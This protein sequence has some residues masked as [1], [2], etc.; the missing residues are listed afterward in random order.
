M[1]I[2]TKLNAIVSLV[3]LGFVIILSVT[4]Y[5]ARTVQTIHNLE[6]EITRLSQSTYRL[7]LE[8]RNLLVSNNRMAS[9]YESWQSADAD[10]Q[11]SMQ[12]ISGHPGLR[13]LSR[14]ARD[15]VSEMVDFWRISRFRIDRLEDAIL[16]VQAVEQI[17]DAAKRGIIPTTQYATTHGAPDSALQELT[18][19]HSLLLAMDESLMTVLIQRSEQ[20]AE[21]IAAEVAALQRRVFAAVA[22]AAVVVLVLAFVLALRFT[23]S[24]GRRIGAIERV[25]GQVAERDITVR[26]ADSGK[27]EIGSL[28][29]H[30][31]GVLTTLALFF[32]SADAAIRQ[33]NELKDT[34]ASSSNE[35][36]AALNQITKNIE[37]IKEQF[38]TLDRNIAGSS[39]A[40]Q[41]IDNQ[42]NNLSGSI[43]QQ[44]GSVTQSS[45]AIEQMNASIQSVARVATERKERAENLRTVVQDGGEQ[46]GATNEV[47]RAV[48][49][50]IDD[51]LQVIEVINSISSQT[52]LLSMNAAI[53]SAHAGEAGRGFA[54]VAEE[55]RKLSES[56]AENATR[57]GSSLQSITDQIR[58]ALLS[59][60]QSYQSYENIARDVEDFVQAMSEIAASMQELSSASGE[61]LVSSA[62]VQRVTSEIRDGAQV[63][64]QR[65][66]EISSA[67]NGIRDIS[68]HVVQG[69]N[70]IDSGARE[71]LDSMV[72]VSDATTES[73]RR[74]EELAELIATF[75]IERRQAEE[76]AQAAADSNA[77]ATTGV[78]L[79]QATAE[80]FTTPGTQSQPPTPDGQTL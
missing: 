74:M 58:E 49:S 47:V 2:S 5:A 63:M 45:A 21:S 31:N 35:S 52:N 55:I 29:Q 16:N 50:E 32:S 30:I 73:K 24:L 76:A 56:T 66:N 15:S 37:S 68:S 64:S 70:E 14:Q 26:M 22:A 38:E 3:I 12:A 61:V 4:V 77:A 67:M 41:S 78:T 79:A 65:S 54:V 75:R 36:A 69:I 33:M 43:E 27:D 11:R 62:D 40:I 17:P 44:A 10:I 28:G 23:R 60:D 72:A 8:A 42:M 9:S 25:M 51:I 57:I 59:S 20:E 39:D 80:P 46:I 1:R 34:M 18:R 7:S 53:E 19:A 6:L 71:I 13:M 48:T